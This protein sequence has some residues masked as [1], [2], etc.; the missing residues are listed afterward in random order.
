MSGLLKPLRRGVWRYLSDRDIL[1]AAL[2][3][4]I[5][6]VGSL[7]LIYVAHAVGVWRLARHSP[8]TP[9][10]RG[11]MLVFGRR[12]VD[13]RPEHDF[14]GRLTRAG[15]NARSGHA[16]RVLLLGGMS[17]GSISE[18]EAG[19][20]WLVEKGWPDDVP[21]LLEQI[22]I[23]SLEN[24]RHAREL[25]RHDAGPD[26]PAVNLVTS[27]YHL[28]RC[29]YLARRLGFDASPIGA[30][31][32]LPLDRRYVLRML[33]EAGYLMWIDTGMR[34]AALIGNHRMAARIS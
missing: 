18:A 11:T 31:A 25:L 23:D 28:A 34:W 5:V 15:N 10:R 13:D 22:S 12:L 20:R 16:D 3:T 9:P 8:V 2:V 14:I 32:R 29:M 19:R 33:M 1:L 26:L 24:L 17:G 6:F 4:T 30:E 21:L 27:R 7:G